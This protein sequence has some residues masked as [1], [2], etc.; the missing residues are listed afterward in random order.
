MKIAIRLPL[1]LVVVLGLMFA[2]HSR[3]LAT[4]EDCDA[5]CGPTTECN[6]ECLVIPEEWWEEA[7]ESTCGEWEGGGS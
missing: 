5:V 4:P 7:Y 3:L 6:E 1:Q 2:Y